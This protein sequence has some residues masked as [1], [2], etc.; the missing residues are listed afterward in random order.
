MKVDLKG[1]KDAEG[2]HWLD[3]GVLEFGPEAAL[4]IS[5]EGAD[6]YVV[7]DGVQWLPQE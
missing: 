6:G 4:V 2:L 7:V 1:N 5:N 3:L